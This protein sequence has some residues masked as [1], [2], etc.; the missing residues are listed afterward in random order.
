MSPALRCISI[1]LMVLGIFAIV[2][3]IVHAQ[4]FAIRPAWADAIFNASFIGGA[5]LG[6]ALLLRPR[7]RAGLWHAAS[8]F[9]R[10]V[11]LGGL[12]LLGGLFTS[13]FVDMLFFLAH[14][15]LA[16]PSQRDLVAVSFKRDKDDAFR[17]CPTY[18]RLADTRKICAPA[19]M[20][21]RIEKGDLFL[22]MARRSPIGMSVQR[23]YRD[24]WYRC[25][26]GHAHPSLAG[27]ERIDAYGR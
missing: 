3:L 21:K 11:Y 4:R 18:F 24:A 19:A 7:L 17:K 10:L 2:A 13:I 6:T 1:V 14:D 16:G 9:Q 15:R 12:A 23:E 5:C 8:I 22:V 20:V 26:P 25:A 27:C